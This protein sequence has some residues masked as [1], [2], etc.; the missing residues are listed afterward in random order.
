M[1]TTS[2]EHNEQLPRIVTTHVYPPIPIRTLD[3]HA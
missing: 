1:T 2:R 3:W